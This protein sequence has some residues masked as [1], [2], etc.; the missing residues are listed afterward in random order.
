MGKG[1]TTLNPCLRCLL[2]DHARPNCSKPPIQCRYCGAD[3]DPSICFHPSA[4]GGARRDSLSSG[5]KSLVR[6]ECGD[7]A[8]HQPA[9][10]SVQPQPQYNQGNGGGTWPPQ[11]Y[12]HHSSA[13]QQSIPAQS[14]GSRYSAHFRFFTASR[15]LHHTSVTSADGWPE[16]VKRGRARISG[17]IG[18]TAVASRS[19]HD[20]GKFTIACQ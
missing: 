10:H 9:A 7:N 5:A 4:P 13:T 1:G 16:S 3:H 14:N 6:R 15:L 19:V 2:T 8:S 20:V 18:N 12:Q 17:I 11:Q